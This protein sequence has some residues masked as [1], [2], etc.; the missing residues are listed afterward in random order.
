MIER[1]LEITG[2]GRR[3]EGLAMDQGLNLFVPYAL[4]GETLLA[5]MDGERARI[6][7]IEKPSPERVQPFCPYFGACGGCQLQHW[8]A[9]PYGIWKRGLVE[10][11][12]RHRG[13]EV[14]I[15]DVIDAHGAGRRRVSLHV[16][17]NEGEVTA[18]FMAARSHVLLDIERCPIVVPALA[19][20]TAI[21]RSLGEKL[22]DCDVALTATNGGIDAAVK[23]ERKIAER[24]APK[25]AALTSD[26]DLARLTVNGDIIVTRRTPSVKMGHS[27]VVLPP[28]SFLQATEAGEMHLADCV[29][30]AAGQAKSVADLF[31]GCGPF[32]LRLAA[33]TRV[34]AFDNDRSAI[35]ALAQAVRATS[36]LK[37]VTA[38]VRDLFREPLVANELKD[39]DAV[40]FDP[41]RAGAEAQ[42]RQIAKSKVKTVVA[43]SCDPV[44]L[45]RDAEIL[46]RG[47]YR[48][49]TVTPIDQF[50]WTSHVE[51]VAVF[52]KV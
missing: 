19:N 41:P 42:A 24:E 16:R 32:A 51:T 30:A 7:R 5:S 23:A 4:P 45:A 46:V 47:G 33:T 14:P 18:G 25:L 29:I 22:G 37:P 13:I 17:R 44:T 20:A 49:E 15:A 21:A 36:G 8:D 3:A 10:T 26:L 48:I 38:T 11:A 27:D 6:V 39:F 50:K 40:V 2:L 52:R 43:V 9:K 12:L 34:S 1:R 28:A 35:A 31:C